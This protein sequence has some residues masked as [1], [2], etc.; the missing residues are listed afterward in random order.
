MAIKIRGLIAPFGIWK[1]IARSMTTALVGTLSFTAASQSRTVGP[2]HG[3]RQPQAR[4]EP[5]AVAQGTNQCVCWEVRTRSC[6]NQKCS[7]KSKSDG[8]PRGD[9]QVRRQV[10]EELLCES[11]PCVPVHLEAVEKAREVAGDAC[12]RDLLH[13]QEHPVLNDLPP[14]GGGG[15]LKP[16]LLSHPLAFGCLARN[17][18]RMSR[19]WLL[20]QNGRRGRTRKHDEGR[21]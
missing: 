9:P 20:V 2:R 7:F 8:E 19:G 13:A 3:C 10:I 1:P 16:G 5:S 12:P 18:Q 11:H 14:I 4:R 15:I 6:A 21:P 17:S